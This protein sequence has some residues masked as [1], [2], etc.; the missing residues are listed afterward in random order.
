MKKISK[1]L[2]LSRDTLR[3][4]ASTQLREIVGALPAASDRLDECVATVN[5]PTC[6]GRSCTPTDCG[7]HSGSPLC[8]PASN[9][10][11]PIPR[12]DA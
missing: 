2:S 6:A 10:A 1:K 8:G 11:C 5:D 12:C 3:V 7:C 4:L 9:T